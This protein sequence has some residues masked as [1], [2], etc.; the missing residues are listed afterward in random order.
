MSQFLPAIL[1]KGIIALGLI[2]AIAYLST[3]IFLIFR[4][5]R[6]IF[7]P[8]AKVEATPAIADL[9]YEDVWLPV[10]TIG[11]AERIHGWWIPAAEP[12]R[13]VLLHLHG[14]GANIGANIGPAYRFHKLGFSVFMIDYRGYGQSEGGFP[15]EAQVYEDTKTAW[16]YLTQERQI[17]AEQIFLY[18]HS[19]GGAIAIDLAVDHPNAAGLI[20]ESTFTSMRQMVDQRGGFGIFP[21]DLLLTQRFNSIAKIR[22]LKL[23]ILLIHGKAD[24]MVPAVMSE[25]LFAAAPEPKELLL[26]PGAGH[27]DVGEIGGEGYLKA[28]DRFVNQV[29]TR[30]KQ[31]AQQQH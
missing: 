1:L 4:Q 27:N 10:E 12:A 5:N 30:Q 20:V 24:P 9:Q 6:F 26:I 28:I 3:C 2:L 11:K 23:P 18:G 22:A 16:N 19:L 17:P 14:N 8:T 29:Q 25:K 15:T 21:A 7:F 13:G 31:L